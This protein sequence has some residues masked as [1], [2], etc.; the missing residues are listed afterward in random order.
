[1]DRQTAIAT[2]K[3]H[4]AEL[5]D[6]GVASL[7]LFGSVARG[8]ERADSDVDVAAT[9]AADARIGI[10]E[11]VTISD[12][13]RDWLGAQVDLVTEPARRDWLQGDIDRDRVRV[14]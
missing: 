4:E 10:F 12:H 14:Y 2:L 5:R 13:L 3:A 9:L 7:S 1:V 11:I 8:E 6:M